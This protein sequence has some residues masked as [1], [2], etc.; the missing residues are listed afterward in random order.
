MVTM[1]R[2]HARPENDQIEPGFP[3]SVPEE[4]ERLHGSLALLDGTMVGVRPIQPED[5]DRLRAFHARLSPEAITFRYF[6]SLPILAPAFVEHLTHVSYT[7]RM[8]LV[9]T[10]GQ[11]SDEQIIAVVRYEGLDAARAEVAFLV[12]DRWQHH[13]IATALLHRLAAYAR[14]L[15]YTTFV[16]E[17][18]ANNAAMREVLRNAGFPYTTVY[19]QGTVEMR[20]DIH[21]APHFDAALPASSQGQIPVQP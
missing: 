10:I 15:G 14:A 20:L 9:A 12:E 11:G 1:T 3:F 7:D 16:A 2:A 18:L 19:D 21:G 5:G 4:A 13:G 17:V 6:H 8:A